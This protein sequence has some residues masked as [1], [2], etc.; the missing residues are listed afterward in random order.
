MEITERMYL[1]NL[2][3]EKETFVYNVAAVFQCGTAPN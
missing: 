2:F 3:K 1:Y